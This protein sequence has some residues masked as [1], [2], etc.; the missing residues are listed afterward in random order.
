MEGCKRHSFRDRVLVTEGE[1]GCAYWDD[2]DHEDEDDWGDGLCDKC[3]ESK[4]TIDEC[5]MTKRDLGLAEHA[6]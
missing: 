4:R 2:W 5:C 3:R 1:E 6:E